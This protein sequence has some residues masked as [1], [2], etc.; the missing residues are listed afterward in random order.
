M[1]R[2]VTTSPTSAARSPVGADQD[3][4]GKSNPP[5]G[6]RRAARVRELAFDAQARLEALAWAAERFPIQ[7]RRRAGT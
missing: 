3:A 4:Q 2:G 1:G 7:P 6:V 5:L